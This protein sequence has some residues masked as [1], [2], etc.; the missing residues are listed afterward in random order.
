MQEWGLEGLHS[1]PASCWLSVQE[2]EDQAHFGLVSLRRAKPPSLVGE[3]RDNCIA[4]PR[5]VGWGAS[6]SQAPAGL[7]GSG[8]SCLLG[9]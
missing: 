1:S 6:G 4:R 8:R 3:E 2:N 7:T 5:A 9:G